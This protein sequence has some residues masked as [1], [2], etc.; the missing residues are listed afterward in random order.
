MA[1]SYDRTAARKSPLPKAQFEDAAHTA[2]ELAAFLYGIAEDPNAEHT[3]ME[4]RNE[5]A[6][7]D[8]VKRRTDWYDTARD[9]YQN[10]GRNLGM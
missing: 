4:F 7:A 2:E 10:L 3:L 5:R 8:Y 9:L 1:Y 6:K